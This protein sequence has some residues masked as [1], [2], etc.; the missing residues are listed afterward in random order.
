MMDLLSPFA[1]AVKLLIAL[2]ILSFLYSSCARKNNPTKPILEREWMEVRTADISG[3]AISPPSIYF[4]FKKGGSFVADV[5]RAKHPYGISYKT[6]GTFTVKDSLLT[7]HTEHGK[8][9]WYITPYTNFI[10][11]Q[12]DDEQ[13]VL[14]A[15]TSYDGNFN[16]KE[17]RTFFTLE[18]YKTYTPQELRTQYAFTT[19]DSLI[20]LENIERGKKLRALNANNRYS[21]VYKGGQEA[22]DSFIQ[23]NMRYP[24]HHLDQVTVTVNFLINKEGKVTELKSSSPV[25]EYYIY[26]AKRVVESMPDWEPAMVR[27]E[28]KSGH[29]SVFIIF[30]AQRDRE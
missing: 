8:K 6:R 26:E 12:L 25:A 20:D 4:R 27:G 28:A 3:A 13:L 16:P 19:Q 7:L 5:P 10:I 30:K 2:S 22:I 1:K 18:K 29:E 9:L 21:P 24:E 23:K 14:L 15:H 11:Q 17:V